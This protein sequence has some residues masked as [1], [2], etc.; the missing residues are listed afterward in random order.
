MGVSKFPTTLA[1]SMNALLVK[2]DEIAFKDGYK[3][4]LDGRAATGLT[5][6]LSDYGTF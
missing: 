2:N 1:H 4:I 3:L 5:I 6:T